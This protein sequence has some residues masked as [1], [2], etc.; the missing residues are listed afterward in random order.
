MNNNNLIIFIRKL[1]KDKKFSLAKNIIDI[2]EKEYP[3]LKFEYALFIGDNDTAYELLNKLSPNELAQ[4]NI[5][6]QNIENINLNNIINYIKSTITENINYDEIKS[7]FPE[8]IELI[9]LE[10]EKAMRNKDK[11][12]AQY[13]KE[14]LEKL[15]PNN[16]YLFSK[17]QHT[18][19]LQILIMGFLIVT[20]IFTIISLFNPIN[21]SIK[22]SVEN[23]EQSLSSN[24]RNL[25]NDIKELNFNINEKLDTIYKNSGDLEKL[26]NDLKNFSND[27]KQ[28]K[29]K[30]ESINIELN[31]IKSK[32]IEL[33][34]QLDSKKFVGN[35][36]NETINIIENFDPNAKET[37]RFLWLLGYQY[38]KQKNYKMAKSLFNLIIDKTVSLNLNDLYFI[39]DVYYYRALTYY[40]S[41]E[42]ENSYLLFK[43]F[44]E[45][46]PDS[47][48]SKHAKY[49]T[50]I[51]GGMK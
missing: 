18:F 33:N 44:V 15:D 16:P 4:Y 28:F 10:F 47:I 12:L 31:K 22:N 48:Y 5:Y 35:I 19:N 14:I 36:P 23:I 41:G 32:V 7:E 6:N 1:L 27:F 40:E 29:E 20:L 3:F 49:F 9:S 42:Y 17:K 50:K 38:Y 21:F 8:I 46:F 13:L 51:L 25:Q 11:N 43:D 26:Y 34:Q 37:L 45:R 30:F 2:F 39:D 24:F